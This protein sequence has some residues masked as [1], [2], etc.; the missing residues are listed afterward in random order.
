MTLSEAFDAYLLELVAQKGDGVLT[1]AAYA[2][3][4]SGF[5]D[6]VKDK[7]AERVTLADLSGYLKF[8]YRSGMAPATII[9]KGTCLKGL[10]GFLNAKKVIAVSLVGFRLPK[11]GL[12]LPDV[13][14]IEEIQALMA[15]PDVSKYTGIRARAMLET[16]YGAGLR[17]SELVHLSSDSVNFLSGYVRVFGKG[18]KE[19]IVP[20]GEEAIF[21]IKA[22]EAA[23][24]KKKGSPLSGY[25][26]SVDGK[27]PLTR[28]AFSL[29]VTAMAKKAGISKR[30]TPHTLRHS[31]ATHLLENGA[32]LRDV[33]ALLGHA[34]I[35]TTQIYTH[36]A[37]ERIRD[38][39]D[40]LVQG[41][42]QGNP[43]AKDDGT[44]PQGF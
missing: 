30:V 15:A 7:P 5:L 12:R 23:Y 21:W 25:L 16:A 44:G 8:L 33:Q 27:K 43:D 13:L 14:T 41:G 2:A 37:G 32:N 40:K 31:F 36:V 34:K 17:V 28:E 39:Y 22:W 6:Y 9:R 11:E 1:K 20:L 24:A 19:R 42:I 26:F 38:D 35:Q 3:D 4:L 10:Y 29:L 18:N